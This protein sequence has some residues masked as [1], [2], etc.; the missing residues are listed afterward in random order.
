MYDDVKPTMEKWQKQGLKIYIYSSGSVEA[1]QLLF[2]YNEKGDMTQVTL[3]R[4]FTTI[5]WVYV[6]II[7]DIALNLLYY[8]AL[9]VY[10]F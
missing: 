1:Q 9:Y 8:L 10:F 3:P 2:K 4:R 6:V 5:T 7:D